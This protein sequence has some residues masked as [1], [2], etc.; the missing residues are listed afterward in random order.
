[1]PPV[2]P[3]PGY[4]PASY[5]TKSQLDLVSPKSQFISHCFI[6]GTVS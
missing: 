1:M 6:T 4:A 3:P 2:P 5:E